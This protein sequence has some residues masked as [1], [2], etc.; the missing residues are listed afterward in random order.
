MRADLGQRWR[1]SALWRVVGA[2][3]A[4]NSEGRQCR[5]ALMKA[6]RQ[7][8]GATRALHFSRPR[9]RGEVCSFAIGIC[10][11]PSERG[12]TRTCATKEGH[13]QAYRRCL[14]GIGVVDAQN[15]VVVDKSVGDAKR[16][17][18]RSPPC[19]AI[20]P[21]S[22]PVLGRFLRIVVSV[23]KALNCRGGR[24]QQCASWQEKHCYDEK[25]R[26]HIFGG[27]ACYAT[28]FVPC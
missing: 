17:P 16:S 4:S 3:A 21:Q 25:A 9:F 20:Q 27:P 22:R 28:L 19:F 12:P 6:T 18:P 13:A 5:L 2:S 7:L 11:Q 14:A 24:R 8:G 15:E 10:P 23:S 1:T 26:K